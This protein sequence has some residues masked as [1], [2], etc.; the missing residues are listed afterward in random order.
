EG[1]SIGLQGVGGGGEFEEGHGFLHPDQLQGTLS[2]PATPEE[3]QDMSAG[4]R[5]GC[6]DARARSSSSDEVSVNLNL[7]SARVAYAKLAPTPRTN[8][9]GSWGSSSWFSL[10][11]DSGFSTDSVPV[12]DRG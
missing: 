3:L 10:S 6:S 4:R 2:D 5:G 1:P 11:S 7:A 12:I 9:W 8:R